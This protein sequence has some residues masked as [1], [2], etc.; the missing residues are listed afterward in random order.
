MPSRSDNPLRRSIGL[1][2]GTSMDG[3]DAAMIETDGLSAVRPVASCSMT[4]DAAFSAALRSIQGANARAHP[5]FAEIERGLTD[6]HAAL[7]LDLIA[8]QG[9][10]A[11]D[12]DVVGFHGQTVF[13]DPAKGITDQI[14]DASRLASRCGIPVVADFRRNDVQSGGQG[15]PFAPLFHAAMA[16]TLERPLAVLNLGGVG[17]VTWL[18]VGEAD[19]LAFDTGP[20]NALIDDWVRRHTGADF[21][22]GGA[23][24][25]SGTIVEEI[26]EGWMA[27]PY[28]PKR[29]PKSLDRNNFDVREV[30]R[31]SPA[32]G[33]ASLM[34][35][36]VRSVAMALD[37]LPVRP[38]RWLIT[39]GGR[40]N[41]ALMAALADALKVPVDPVETVGWDGDALEAQAFAYLA[42]RSL[43][44]LPL[45]LPST[46]GVPYPATGGRL[47]APR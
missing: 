28:F 42:V 2:T 1:M 8:S 32:D 10:N 39:G 29:P 43:D 9:M 16:S 24:A 3:V 35:F 31:L 30:D 21:D 33:A 47:H 22:A 6:H 11:G 27:N 12:I 15:A 23:L 25:L 36:T 19:I 26:V 37:H 40:H 13:H 41:L 38:L 46:T 18:G 14:G 5:A 45:S 17:N 44:G 20:A 4:Y 7:V 34:A